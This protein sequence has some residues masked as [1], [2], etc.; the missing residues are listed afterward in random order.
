MILPSPVTE[1]SSITVPSGTF[2]PPI[3][4][5]S[6]HESST[7]DICSFL[8]KPTCSNLSTVGGLQKLSELLPSMGEAD[9]WNIFQEN[10]MDLDATVN[11]ILVESGIFK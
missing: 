10:H 2:S 3:N 11:N 5:S 9:L 4:L 8:A 7:A 1:P 6:K